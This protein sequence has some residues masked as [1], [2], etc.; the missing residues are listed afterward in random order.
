MSELIIREPKIEDRDTFISSM[1]RSQALHLPWVKAPQTEEE[2]E[3][4]IQHSQLTHQKCFLA[5][6]TLGN[7]TGVFNI[8]EIVMGMFQSAYLGFYAVAHYAG[9]GY[10]SRG[11]KLVLKNIFEEIK[12]HR[13]EAN[14]QPENIRS[15]HLIKANGFSKEGFSPRYLNI[16]GGWRDHER[17]AL[18]YEDWIEC[19]RLGS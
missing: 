10:M 18:T 7:I 19:K 2:F 5:C 13:I 6:D 1:Q 17:W 4:Y 15:I 3:K 16:D 9:Q 14:I 8:S 11:L 12:L